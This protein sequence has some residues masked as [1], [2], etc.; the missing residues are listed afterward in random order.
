MRII[1]ILFLSFSCLV[2]SQENLNAV[3]VDYIE[4]TDFGILSNT[5]STLIANSKSASYKRK[6]IK[7]DNIEEDIVVIKHSDSVGHNN[8]NKESYFSN[9]QDKNIHFI[10]ESVNELKVFRDSIVD[11]NWII[12]NSKFETFLGFKCQSAKGLFR[13]REYTAWF[14]TEI[15]ISYGPWKLHG[16]PGLILKVKDKSNQIE[17]LATQII[18]SR[19]EMPLKFTLDDEEKVYDIKDYLL[20]L[21]NEEENYFKEVMTKVLSKMPRGATINNINLDSHENNK[22]EINFE[23]EKEN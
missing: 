16:L 21:N 8:F 7:Y 14:T 20:L 6:N 23:W 5:N 1:K 15:P 18:F 13:G 9:L 17:I 10:D 2:N 12:D 19:F 22:Y 3:I 4:I 11:I